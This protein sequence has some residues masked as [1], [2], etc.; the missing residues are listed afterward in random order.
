MALAVPVCLSAAFIAW[1]VMAARY[2]PLLQSFSSFN[3]RGRKNVHSKEEKDADKRAQ[4]TLLTTLRS[5]YNELGG[6]R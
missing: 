4:E 6:I 5:Q 1:I 3:R 2:V